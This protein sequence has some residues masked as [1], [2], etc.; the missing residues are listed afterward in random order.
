[1]DPLQAELSSGRHLLPDGSG[2]TRRRSAAIPGYQALT[3]P[4]LT[5]KPEEVKGPR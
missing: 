3:D 5:N 4:R 1:M 2:G